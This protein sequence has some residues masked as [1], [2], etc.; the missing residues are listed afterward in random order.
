MTHLVQSI[1]LHFIKITHKL[2]FILLNIYKCE[3]FIDNIKHQKVMYDEE[4]P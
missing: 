3:H 1:R 4:N 2:Y